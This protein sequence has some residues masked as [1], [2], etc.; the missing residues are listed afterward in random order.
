[1]YSSGIGLVFLY[2]DFWLGAALRKQTYLEHAAAFDEARLSAAA[3]F[4][5]NICLHYKIDCALHATSFRAHFTPSG[6][7]IIL[8]LL[9]PYINTVRQPLVNYLR[10]E[11]F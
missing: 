4:H 5:T 1:M 9:S 11:I 3:A 10:F 7:S 6:T 2:E 8:H